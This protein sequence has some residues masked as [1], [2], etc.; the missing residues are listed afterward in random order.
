MKT[1]FFTIIVTLLTVCTLAKAQDKAGSLVLGF[2][3]LGGISEKISLD[4][5]KY[6]YDYKSFMNA[7]LGY[8]RVFKGAITLTE[9]SYSQGKFDKYDLQ[10]TSLWFNPA[11]EDDV[12]SVAVTQYIG[13]TIN[14]NKRVQLPLY[15][16]IG[17]D[18]VNG[19]P[20]HNLTFD[21][22]AK[23]RIKFYITNNFG[24]YV[25]ATGRMGWGAKSASEKSSNYSSSKS[26]TITNTIW[27][28]DAGII[29]GL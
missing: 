22:A 14:P 15:I 24:I 12:Y 11:Q 1:K 8:E 16:G 10:G 23:A 25:G 2:S 21:V 19:G 26:Y 4:D 6:K 7:S 18:Y 28:A 29:I 3:P 20:L 17:G 5:E 27:A 13:T 9:V